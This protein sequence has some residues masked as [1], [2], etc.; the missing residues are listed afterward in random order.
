MTQVHA[1]HK[2]GDYQNREGSRLYCKELN[3]FH[4]FSIEGSDTKDASDNMASSDL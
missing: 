1:G 2:K 4:N 3:L